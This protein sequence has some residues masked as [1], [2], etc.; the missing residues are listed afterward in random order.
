MQ[1][2]KRVQGGSANILA[3]LEAICRQRLSGGKPVYNLS[4]G[5]PDLPPAKHVMQAMSEACLHPENYKY[6]ISDFPELLEAAAH[7]YRSRFGV[8]LTPGQITSVY[9]TQ[10]G[11]AHI[12]FPLCNPGDVVLVPDPGYPVFR[13]G[14]LMAGAELATMPLHAEKGYLIDFDAISPALAH[15]ARVMVVSYPNNPVTARATPEFYERLVHFAKQYDIFVIHDN[16]YCELVPEGKPGI[17]FLAVK[18]AMDIGMEFNSLSK[19]YNLT[20]MRMSFA[21]GKEEVISAFRTFRS[22]I[23]YGPFPASQKAAIAAL[24]G[25][26]DILAENRREYALRREALGS[27]LNSIGWRVPMGDATMF[28][29]Y[30]LP[31]GYTDDVAF[32][33]K[34]LEETGVICVPGS[35]FGG[36]GKGYVRFALV[37]PPEKLRQAIASIAASGI[38]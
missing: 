31:R 15:R 7:W 22:A 37:L 14:P 35:S 1:L 6:A 26:Q 33:Y 21:L 18:G 12:A 34:L 3:D 36:M 17:S 38:L 23:D 30:P 19:S 32:T 13:A 11:M 20:G 4:A 27:G 29:W 10:E 5:T 28:T 24:T 2:A 16:A 9:G 8:A 25:P